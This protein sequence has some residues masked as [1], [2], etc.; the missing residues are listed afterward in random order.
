MHLPHNTTN[1]GFLNLKGDK[2]IFF[3][4]KTDSEAELRDNPIQSCIR[5]N[6]ELVASSSIIGRYL[7][8]VSLIIWSPN[9]SGFVLY[10]ILRMLPKKFP[11]LKSFTQTFLALLARILKKNTSMQ[12]ESNP[13]PQRYTRAP[14]LSHQWVTQAGIGVV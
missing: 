10:L 6:Q 14:N 5:S 9:S 1:V 4:D 12:V 8:I 7:Q 11:S 2:P 3:E 13:G